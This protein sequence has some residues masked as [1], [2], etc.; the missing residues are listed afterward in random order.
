[1]A[2]IITLTIETLVGMYAPEIVKVADEA[3][4]ITLIRM[5]E[6]K[7]W[8]AKRM[9]TLRTALAGFEASAPAPVQEPARKGTWVQLS[10]SQRAECRR[11]IDGN[12]ALYGTGHGKGNVTYTD[13]KAQKAAR[14]RLRNRV[15]KNF[16]ANTL[17]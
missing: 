14:T 12:P 13:R 1:M 15:A 7:N 11:L 9:N 17:G 6:D 3:Q 5:G 8:T 16:P 2:A 10:D 4:L